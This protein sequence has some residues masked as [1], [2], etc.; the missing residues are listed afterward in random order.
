MTRQDERQA[1]LDVLH[2]HS[3]YADEGL[4]EEL[5]ELWVDNA[6]MEVLYGDHVAFDHH[7]ADAIVSWMRDIARSAHFQRR[8]LVLNTVFNELSEST[9]STTSCLVVVATGAEESRVSATGIYHDR[10][11]LT[12][13]SWLLGHRRAVFDGVPEHG[14]RGLE[15]SLP[16]NLEMPP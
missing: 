16:P 2:R 8:H 12:G 14:R 9:A 1:L 4:F 5:S 7:G 15:Q 13:G 3:L 10:W 6:R 11:L